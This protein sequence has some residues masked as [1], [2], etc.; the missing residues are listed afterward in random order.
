MNVLE[1]NELSKKYPSFELKGASFCLR[2]GRITGFIGR[3]GAG[4]ST[5]LKAMLGLVH[6]DGGQVRFFGRDFKQNEMEIKRRIGFAA[7]EMNSYRMKKLG[8]ITKVV[9]AFYD[10]WDENAYKGYLQRFELDEKKTPAQLSA[11][12]RVKYSLAL[13]L[14]HRAEIL[15]L[16]EPTS[17]LDPVSRDD[18]LETF[19]QLRDEGTTILFSTHIISDLDKCADD[20]VYIQSGE[21]V[22]TSDLDSFEQSYK[23][24]RLEKEDITDELRPLI[25]GLG[26]RRKGYTA[27][28]KA[29]DAR[30]AGVE[31]E[32]A[33]L[34][35]IMIHLEKA[36][37]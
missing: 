25:I 14:S 9:R 36:R 11:G 13:Q 8:A 17:G 23:L 18:L 20:I 37:S 21:I 28:I 34:E 3:N 16:D 2:K 10:S 27:L 19:M 30:R 26:R 6:A 31:C 15:I 4:K 5:V 1:V 33:S 32:N 12:M 24:L 29:E 22:H 7:G 35:D